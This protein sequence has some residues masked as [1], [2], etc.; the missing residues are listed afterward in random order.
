MISLSFIGQV[1]KWVSM[2]LVKNYAPGVGVEVSMAQNA[3]S[4]WSKEQGM[5]TISTSIQTVNLL[6]C[7]S[8]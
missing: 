5:G 7:I 1:Q 2:F 4:D 3:G 8:L 6:S